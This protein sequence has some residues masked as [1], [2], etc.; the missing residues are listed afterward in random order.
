MLLKAII[1]KTNYNFNSILANF[2]TKVIYYTNAAKS[3][4]FIVP[5]VTG[6]RNRHSTPITV[7]VNWT[8]NIGT[9]RVFL[10]N[11]KYACMR[12]LIG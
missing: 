1:T 6:P 11:Q 4:D 5:T 2:E 3:K 8:P 12:M 7:Y 10:N 9:G